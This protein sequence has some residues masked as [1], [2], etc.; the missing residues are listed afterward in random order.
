[1]GRDAV[2]VH[3]A[4]AG[5][6]SECRRSDGVVQEESGRLQGAAPH[7]VRGIAED[8]HGEDSEV[9]IARDGEGGVRVLSP[10]DLLSF[11]M[12]G[13]SRSKN[14]VASLAYVPAISIHVQR[15]ASRIEMP[16]TRP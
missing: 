10:T 16:G 2:C 11:V 1:M 6:A 3:R 13:H 14:G 7:R 8:Q 5:P 4:E 15:S 12:A 9:Q